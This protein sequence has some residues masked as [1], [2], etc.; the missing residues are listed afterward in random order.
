[1][2][3]DLDSLKGFSTGANNAPFE[4]SKSISR[5]QFTSSDPAEASY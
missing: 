1:M 4:Q 3:Q 5:G 2:L